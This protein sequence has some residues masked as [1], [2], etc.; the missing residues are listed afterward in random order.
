MRRDQLIEGL[1]IC[2]DILTLGEECTEGV[3]ST[4]AGGDLYI[5]EL[6][7]SE[8]ARVRLRDQYVGKSYAASL[9]YTSLYATYGAD[10]SGETDFAGHTGMRGDGKVKI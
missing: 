5:R 3:L 8:I 2:A 6:I 10:L 1:A 9:G 7:L 4:V